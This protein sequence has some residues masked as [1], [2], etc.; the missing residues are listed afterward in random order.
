MANVLCRT[1][2]CTHNEGGD[3][4]ATSI[5][6]DECYECETYEYR[7]ELDDEPEAPSTTDED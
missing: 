3:C 7:T 4:I 2:D 1:T 6:I 5:E